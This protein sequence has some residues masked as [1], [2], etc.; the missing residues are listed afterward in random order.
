MSTIEELQRHID[1]RIDRID[2]IEA[3]IKTLSSPPPTGD[4]IGIEEAMIEL[5]RSKQSIYNMVSLRQVPFSKIRGRLYF[6][7]KQ[8]Q[9]WMLSN[10]SKSLEELVLEAKRGRK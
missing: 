4:V 3:M 8:L 7:R 5:R 1:D 2:R 10:P 9:E 6:S